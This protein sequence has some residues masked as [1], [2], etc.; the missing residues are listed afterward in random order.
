M[1]DARRATGRTVPVVTAADVR[2]ALWS[3]VSTAA[4][5]GIAAWVVPGAEVTAFAALLL[6][7]LAV[8]VGDVVLRPLLRRVA[9]RLGVVGA[10][11][12]GV[13]AQVLVAGAALTYLPG[14][15]TS[16]WATVLA[17]LVVAGVVMALGRWAV[18]ASDNEYVLG[19]LLRRARRQAGGPHAVPV[20]AD[21][22]G[23]GTGGGTPGPDG[24]PAGMLVVVLDGVARPTLDYALQAGLVPTLARWL[25]S[26]S[27]RLATWWARVPATTPASTVGIL[28]GTTEHVPAFRWWSRELGRLVVTNRPADAAAVEAR[29][30]DG[31]GLLAGGGAAV[32]TMFSGDATTTLLVMSRASAGLGPGQPFVRFFAG[33]F[34]LV[35]AV[36]GATGELV[37]E[38]YQGWQQAVRGVR[39]R[40]PRLGWYPVLRAGTN[41][42]LRDLSTTLVAEQ[43]VRGAPVVCVD[44]VDYDEI[45]HHAGPL[46]PESLRALEGLDRVVG[47][48]E[49]VAAVAPRRYEVVVLSDHGQSLGATFEQVVGRTFLAE[50]RRLMAPGAAGPDERR[51]ADGAVRPGAGGPPVPGAAGR[52]RPAGRRRPAAPD[53]EEWGPANAALHALRGPARGPDDAGRMMV[54]PD[55]TEREPRA[56]RA[57]DE[58]PEVAVVGSGNLG[59]VW[60]PRE[61]RRLT[62]DEVRDRWPALLD[63]LLANPAV[64][65]VVVHERPAARPAGT[66]V[67]HG[68]GGTR[69]LVTG[70]VDGDDPLAPYGVRAAPDLLRVARLADAG[71]LVLL[72]RVDDVGMVHAF[73]GLVG[74]H[75]G[76]G[77]AQNAAVLVHPARLH[78]PDDELEDVD[79]EPVL[80]GAEAVHRRL[81]AWLEDLGV[82]APGLPDGAAA[83]AQDRPDGDARPGEAVATEPPGETG[84]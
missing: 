20:P 80:V 6:A 25:G 1:T 8:G 16:S 23:T 47:L 28:H 40:V 35:R 81:V 77:G 61:A 11:V 70:E 78:V 56:A 22:S 64:G 48:W 5:L 52:A 4:G 66:V 18:G 84:R 13:A 83:T 38:L 39:P 24:R 12:S 55:R 69:D 41:V 34:V 19:D 9:A 51:D 31:A 3:L 33:P 43:L 44:L 49:Q 65:V 54:G 15:R 46:R 73:E 27:H 29:S 50:V 72:S 57:H 14:L 17:V 2:G 26:G 30:G 59:M 53:T 36:V 74:S 62:G 37:K 75:G 67:A 82:R 76:L 68:P 60:F 10:L 79:G 21:P 7:A 45:A 58:L 63:G 42:V 71:D 32:S